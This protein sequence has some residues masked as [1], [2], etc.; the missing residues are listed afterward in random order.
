MI[1]LRR[2][3]IRNYEC[4][5]YGHLNNA[6]YLRFMQETA[7]DAS[8]AAGYDINKYQE[9]KRTWLIRATDIEYMVQVGYGDTLEVKTWVEDFRRASSR[10]RYEFYSAEN[11]ALVARAYTD[12]VFLNTETNQ[13]ITVPEEMKPAFFPEGVPETFPTR[14]P[15]PSAPPP[16]PGAYTLS[17]QVEWQALDG[18]HHV[19][20]A[21]YLDYASE[22]GFHAVASFNWPWSRMLAE[23]FGVLLRRNQIQYLQPAILGDQLEITTWLSDVRAV[24]ATRHYHIRRSS[25]G[26]DIAMIHA[27]GVCVELSSGRPMR[28]P[29]EMLEDFAPGISSLSIS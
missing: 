20:N 27:L 12:W 16:P 13:P 9:M 19:N 11:D 4:D 17:R 15:F 14:L 1:H 22:C 10:R 26:A 6:N 2:F 3:R 5:A 28:W 25:D 8:A 7:F 23:G 24:Q 18:M 29:K 21:I